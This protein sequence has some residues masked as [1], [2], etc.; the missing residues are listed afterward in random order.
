MVGE[1]RLCHID[2]SAK[3]FWEDVDNEYDREFFSITHKKNAGLFHHLNIWK[4]ESYQKLQG[5]YPVISIT[6]AN[7]KERT[8]QMAK[9][10]IN[11][12]L[13]DLY[14]KHI[15]LLGGD[16]LTA[17]GFHSQIH[18]EPPPSGAGNLSAPSAGRHSGRDLRLHCLPGAGHADLP[19]PGGIL[20]GPG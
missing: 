11:Q 19:H 20:F 17:H 15:F 1:K 2:Y 13:T 3:A 6:F 12:I 9:Q 7:V 14:N 8:F 16:L 5:T 10:R 4:E 18:R